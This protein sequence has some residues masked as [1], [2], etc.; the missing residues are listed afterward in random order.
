MEQTGFCR[1]H[2]CTFS[3]FEM[4]QRLAIYTKACVGRAL[5]KKIQSDHIPI[6]PHLQIEIADCKR[7]GS[8]DNR[9]PMC[10]E[11]RVD[12]GRH[13]VLVFLCWVKDH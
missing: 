11:L 13:F 9:C 5:A 8:D 10:F 6:E 1:V 3:Q 12:E 7:D 4:Q 2:S